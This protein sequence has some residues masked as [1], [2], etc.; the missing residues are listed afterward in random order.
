[1]VGLLD[2]KAAIITGGGSGI[3][4]ATARLFAQQGCKEECTMAQ[5]IVVTCAVTGSHQNFHKHP[6]FPITPKEIAASW[7][8]GP[9]GRRQ[10]AG[11]RALGGTPELKMGVPVTGPLV[12]VVLIA[13]A[14]PGLGAEAP[15]APGETFRDC[16]VC[17]QMVVIPAGNFRM[18]SPSDEAGRSAAE[19]PVHEVIIAR[20]FA[21]GRYEITFAEWNACVAERGCS[22]RPGEAFRQSGD[23]PMLNLAWREVRAYLRWLSGRT[24][25]RYRLPSEAEWEFAARAGTT[26]AYF[27]GDDFGSGNTYCCN[28]DATWDAGPATLPVGSYPANPFGLHD[29]LGGAWEWTEDCWHESYDGA[30]TDG[31]AWTEGGDCRRRVI[32]GG[33]WNA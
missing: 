13:G 33:A 29:T 32:R 7:P 9:G 1:M 10:G 22:A 3:G 2:G 20:P 27:W 16:P 15:A 26:T 8:G 5:E 19:G 12:L 31:R 30:P 21:L 11:P 17:P 25:A 6:N 23:H 28:T 24:G 14:A 18:G 4:E